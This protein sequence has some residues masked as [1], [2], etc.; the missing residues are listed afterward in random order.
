MGEVRCVF[1]ARAAEGKDSG[2]R[3]DGAQ[4][5]VGSL[6]CEGYG[7]IELEARGHNWIVVALVCK[8]LHVLS[9]LLLVIAMKGLWSN[10]FNHC[11]WE[12]VL[13]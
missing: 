6:G 3:G 8:L 9:G 12:V 2:L 4:D 7:M 13:M 5:F 11:G 1:G 10:V